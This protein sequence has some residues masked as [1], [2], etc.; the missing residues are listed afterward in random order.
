MSTKETKNSPQEE[1]SGGVA[2]L[3]KPKE[4]VFEDDDPVTVLHGWGRV[5]P[6]EKHYID[7]VLFQN[8]IARNVPYRVA[9]HWLKGTRPDG[10]N[11]LICG[12]VTLQAVLPN[13]ATEADF[14]KAT[15]ITPMPAENFAAMLAGVDLDELVRAMGV[16]KVKALIDSLEHRLPPAQRRV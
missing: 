9:K 11:E 14:A 2:V 12:K 4:I 1:P 10:K 8:G 15:G 13:D 3:D 6:G 16:T 5:R 7:K